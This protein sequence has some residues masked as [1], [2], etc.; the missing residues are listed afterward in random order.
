[1]NK[2]Y[3]SQG[4]NCDVVVSSKIR[5]ARNLADAPFPSRM[6]NEVRKSVCKKIYAAVKS[7]SKAGD[8]DL[9]EM[10]ALA[11]IKKIALAE[12]G[13]ISPEFAKQSK[14]CGV[15]VSKDE[16]VSIM[17]CEEDHI[18]LSVQ[19]V[20][21]SL[22][23][24]YQKADELDDILIKNLNIAF[25]ERLGFLTSNPMNLGTGLKASLVLHLPAITTRGMAPSLTGMVSKLG[26]TIKPIWGE[27]SGFY[28][29]S[30]RICLGITEKSAIDNLNGICDQIVKQE[31]VFRQELKD[32]EDFEDRIFRAMG[33]LKMARRLSVKEFYS[34]ISLARL[35]ISIG[36]FDESYETVNRLLHSVG[37]ATI[38]SGSD[39]GMTVDDADKIRAQ[40]VRESLK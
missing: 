1:M 2:W 25:D 31:R 13:I 8:F 23:A 15:L 36:S 20:G 26:F 29:L 14:N 27:N 32:Y 12:Q 16:S 9:T 19:T 11:D 22:E 4:S 5:L 40:Y 3:N 33:T 38:M 30:N 17:M 34:L 28:E 24:A 7:S 35:G 37:T 10:T 21:Q 39:D 6:S 18:R